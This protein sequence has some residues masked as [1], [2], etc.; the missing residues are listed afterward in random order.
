MF[1]ADKKE[2]EQKEKEENKPKNFAL[3]LAPTR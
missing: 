3:P 1:K 2:A